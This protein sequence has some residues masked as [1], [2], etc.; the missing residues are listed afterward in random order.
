MS[1]ISSSNINYGSSKELVLLLRKDINYKHN[2]NLSW[3]ECLLVLNNVINL[4]KDLLI[5]EEVIT[6][7]EPIDK[8]VGRKAYVSFFG[9]KYGFKTNSK[10][11]RQ[12]MAYNSLRNLLEDACNNKVDLNV[13]F[14]NDNE[15]L[16]IEVQHKIDKI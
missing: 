3:N 12:L 1:F 4:I 13:V 10:K 16:P 5:D 11:L 8:K 9:K 2:F 14:I 7:I 6:K 15:E